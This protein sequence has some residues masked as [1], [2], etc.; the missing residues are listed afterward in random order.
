[1]PRST[2]APL[3]AAGDNASD[4]A[5]GRVADA[6]LYGATGDTGHLAAHAM[7]R[8]GV[9][10]VLAGRNRE[11]LQRMAAEFDGEHPV[12]VA[13]HDDPAALAEVASMGS[14][15][16]STAGPFVEVGEL[17][18]AA[19]IASGAHYL[20]STGESHFMAQTYRPPNASAQEQ[21]LR[22]LHS[23]AFHYRFGDRP[24]D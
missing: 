6:V 15:L 13:R 4:A 8:S 23:C 14:V 21:G 19:A 2:R 10:M 11:S 12:A 22:V 18:V 7:E 24:L 20:D 17:T 1:M 16:A 5:A 9:S 3:A